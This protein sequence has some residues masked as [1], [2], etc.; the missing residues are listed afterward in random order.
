MTSKRYELRCKGCDKAVAT[1]ENNVFNYLNINQ[2]FNIHLLSCPEL[3]RQKDHESWYYIVDSNSSEYT[4][5]VD[6][7]ISTEE[8][9]M[10]KIIIEKG[11]NR[12]EFVAKDDYH[13][14]NI[15]PI[16]LEQINLNSI[17]SIKIEKGEN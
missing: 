5:K 6:S 13:L 10:Y 17:Y 1:S 9:K 12:I 16:F 3:Q 2:T 15:L 4:K 8:I 11:H 14:M 7:Q